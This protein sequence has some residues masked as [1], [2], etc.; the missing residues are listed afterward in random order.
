MPLSSLLIHLVCGLRKQ[1]V[2]HQLQKMCDDI[3]LTFIAKGEP[4]HLILRLH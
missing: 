2:P 4:T 1:V 3:W